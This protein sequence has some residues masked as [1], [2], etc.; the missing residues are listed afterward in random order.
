MW[1]GYTRRSTLEIAKNTGLFPIAK[2]ICILCTKSFLF[3]M[4][5]TCLHVNS[6]NNLA[7][8]LN[9][10]TETDILFTICALVTKFR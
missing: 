2:S 6:L 4:S 1:T 3:Q 7:G 10:F 9:I 5:T 8:N